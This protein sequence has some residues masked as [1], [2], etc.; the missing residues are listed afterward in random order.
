MAIGAN[1]TRVAVMK[2]NL[3]ARTAYKELRRSE[4][5]WRLSAHTLWEEYY[6]ENRVNEE[7]GKE[8]ATPELEQKG[9]LAL[10]ASGPEHTLY[11]FFPQL[12]KQ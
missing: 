5:R 2:V 3:V 4:K 12:L 10:C 7:L 9:K 11:L 6:L 8:P 1:R